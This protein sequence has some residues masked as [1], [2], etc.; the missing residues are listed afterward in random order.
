MQHLVVVVEG[1]SLWIDR[2]TFWD[3]LFPRSRD[4]NAQHIPILDG[5]VGGDKFLSAISL[6]ERTLDLLHIAAGSSVSGRPYWMLPV[7]ST[8]KAPAYDIDART[9]INVL[10]SLRLPKCQLSPLGP[11]VYGPV[12]YAGGD[13][14]FVDY[15]T[16]WMTTTPAHACW[17]V[18]RDRTTLA[19]LQTEPL[20]GLGRQVALIIRNR[21]EQEHKQ[22]D[23]TI[24]TKK[25]DNLN[26]VQDVHR[27]L[28]LN[29]VP[30]PIYLG[31]DLG[32]AQMTAFPYAEADPRVDTDKL[33]VHCYLL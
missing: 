5:Y 26:E 30:L 25:N 12:S 11:K 31:E 7:A 4:Y 13:R 28:D 32:R 17:A 27:L 6:S 2:G 3:V 1:I 14:H 10:S 20:I 24:P 15:G 8:H 29:G 22:P 19:E 23:K 21:T 16:R 33:C 9:S 18:I